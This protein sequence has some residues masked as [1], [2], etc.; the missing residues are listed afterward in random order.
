ML[1][2]DYVFNVVS[3]FTAAPKLT[4]D[5][6]Q[7]DITLKGGASYIINVNY[8]GQPTPKISWFHGE[9]ELINERVDIEIGKDFTRLTVTGLT[10]KNAGTYKVTAE[11]EV[12]SESAEFTLTVKGKICSSF[13]IYLLFI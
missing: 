6:K 10:A 2:K 13:L 12:G 11:N 8:T 5:K 4:Y 3:L 9:E 1:C 7:V